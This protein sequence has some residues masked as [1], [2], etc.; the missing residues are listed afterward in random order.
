MLIWNKWIIANTTNEYMINQNRSCNRNQIDKTV[1]TLKQ[2]EEIDDTGTFLM[3]N[4]YN[5]NRNEADTVDR[6][7]ITKHEYIF[8]AIIPE[9]EVTDN[10]N[11]D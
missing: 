8:A 11:R 3:N 9:F 7:K 4:N 10:I 1:V 5:Q 6:P 2:R